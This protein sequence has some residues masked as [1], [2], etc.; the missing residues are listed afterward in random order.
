MQFTNKTL[1]LF[2][3]II[4]F[5]VSSVQLSTGVQQLKRNECTTSNGNL[6]QIGDGSQVIAVN[7]QKD[8]RF[9][10]RRRIYEFVIFR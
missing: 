2:T 6:T 8:V 9:W 4:L 7:K 5:V 3:L 1:L 10:E